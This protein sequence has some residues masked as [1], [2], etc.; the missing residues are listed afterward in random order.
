MMLLSQ[1][2]C[3][4][5]CSGIDCS[6]LGSYLGLSNV[7][8]RRVVRPWL[9]LKMLDLNPMVIAQLKERSS[10]FPDVRKGVLVPMVSYP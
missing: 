5:S 4:P 8:C 10:S 2:N 9:G 6:V 1:M 7:Q 3:E